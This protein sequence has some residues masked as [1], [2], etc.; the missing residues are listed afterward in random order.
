MR[1][2]RAVLEADTE[3]LAYRIY[4][5]DSLYSAGNNKRLT[6][7][8]YDLI[9]KPQEQINAD[10]IAMDIIERMGLKVKGT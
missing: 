2:V 8:W 10:D 6:Q 4:V 7:R 1:Y 5:T 9:R 3:A